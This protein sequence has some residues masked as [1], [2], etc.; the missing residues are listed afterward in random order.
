MSCWSRFYYI[1]FSSLCFFFKTKGRKHCKSKLN[2]AQHVNNLLYLI[3]SNFVE[4]KRN[5][6]KSKTWRF[7][8]VPEKKREVILISIFGTKKNNK[9]IKSGW[10]IKSKNNKSHAK[11][12]FFR[13]P[14][15]NWAREVRRDGDSDQGTQFFFLQKKMLF[16]QTKWAICF[17]WIYLLYSLSVE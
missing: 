15:S 11:T 1:F 5:S 6:N 4:V 2:F 17:I 3:L 9:S 8:I 16:R 13:Y 7:F 14:N 12:F 10:E